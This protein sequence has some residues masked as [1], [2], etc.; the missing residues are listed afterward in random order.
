MFPTPTA[1]PPISVKSAEIS[2]QKS[3]PALHGLNPKALD[4][5]MG[6]GKRNQS[7]N[8]VRSPP[9]NFHPDQ[10][11]ALEGSADQLKMGKANVKK[12]YAE[13]V[14]HSTRST[15]RSHSQVLSKKMG[16]RA[17]PNGT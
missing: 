5:N 3:A 16:T 10:A 11:N 17:N 9:S 7:P 6:R 13:V 8:K 4:P 2:H 12:N 14:I 1:T 15:C